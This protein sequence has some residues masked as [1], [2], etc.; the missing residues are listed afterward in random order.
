[1]A[2]HPCTNARFPKTWSMYRRICSDGSM[3]EV[4]VQAI[5]HYFEWVVFVPAM[6]SER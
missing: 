1:M 4:S 6:R 3:R 2:N 5:S